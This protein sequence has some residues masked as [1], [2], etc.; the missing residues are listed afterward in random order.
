ML[1]RLHPVEVVHEWKVVAPPFHLFFYS[2][3]TTTVL[4][5]K[6]CIRDR[7]RTGANPEIHR[8]VWNNITTGKKFLRTIRNLETTI[9]ESHILIVVV[10]RAFFFQYNIKPTSLSI[11]AQVHNPVSY[12]H[13]RHPLVTLVS[14]R[15][16][17]ASSASEDW[18]RN[19]DPPSSSTATT[20]G[21][22]RISSTGGVAINDTNN[23]LGTI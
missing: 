21:I 22:S 11:I 6:M 2:S 23:V 18:I 5:W 17:V 10:S 13:L 8:I 9:I 1:A 3:S 7:I 20:P 19:F 14:T 16:S 4:P 12:T 15:R